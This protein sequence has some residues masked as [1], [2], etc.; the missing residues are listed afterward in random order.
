MKKELDE[1]LVEKY[2]LIFKDRYGSMQDTAM[3]W[4]FSCGD[5]W[6]YL[7]DTLCDTIQSHI[8]NSIK[9][10]NKEISQVVAVQVKEKFG[11]LRFYYNGGDDYIDGAVML[12]ELLSGKICDKCGNP[13]KLRDGGWVRTLCNEHA[14]ELGYKGND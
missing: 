3:C 2:P 4:G 14:I 6:Y 10:N 1:K 7:I 11:T 9:F 8:D 13:G 5:G 12:A